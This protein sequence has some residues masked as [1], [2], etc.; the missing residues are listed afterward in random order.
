MPPS[1]EDRT[2]GRRP[3]PRH[4]SGSPAS[5]GPEDIFSLDLADQQRTF[6]TYAY[7]ACQVEYSRN[8]LFRSGRQMEDIFDAAGPDPVPP[9]CPS[10]DHAVRRQGAPAHRPR[11][12][13]P[14]WR[15][16]RLEVAIETPAYDLTKFKVHSGNLEGLHQRR[17][18]P[19]VRRHRPQHQGPALR[20]HPGQVRAHRHPPPADGRGVLH[21]T[22]LRSMP[23]SSP[24]AC[25]MPCPPPPSSAAPASAASM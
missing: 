10:G 11:P 18:R 15:S 14:G 3:A 24:T 4:T 6:F 25:S 2:C 1:G 21:G 13:R 9:G 17:T 5:C 20:P 16:P 7:S 8:L 12:P 22:G 19:A 23:A